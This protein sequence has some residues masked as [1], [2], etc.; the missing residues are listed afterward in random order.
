MGKL[1]FVD[2]KADRASRNRARRRAIALGLLSRTDSH[3]DVDHIDG[4]PRNN[5]P[6]NLRAI[7]RRENRRQGRAE[8]FLS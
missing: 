3:L 8:W 1:S 5:S 6:E 4:D 7:P 2:Q